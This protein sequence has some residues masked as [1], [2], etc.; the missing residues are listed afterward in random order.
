MNREQFRQWCQQSVMPT[1]KSI[2][3]LRKPLLMGVLNITPDS[4][5]D[6]GHF[7][8]LGQAVLRAQ[9][10]I[11][12]GADIIDIGGE[13]TKPGATVVSCAEELQRVIPVIEHI[14]DLS[15]ICISIDTS[16]AEVM[17]AAVTAGASMINDVR[18]LMAPGAMD[19]AVRSNVPV[20]LMHMQGLPGSMQEAPHYTTD[21]IDE[22]NSFF[23]QRIAACLQAGLSREQLILDPGFG[24]G[25]LVSHNLSI[26]K[27]LSEF[28]RHQLPLLLGVSRKSTIG[29]VLQRAVSARLS[30]SIA[31][32]VFA[33]LQG[34]SIIRTHDVDETNQAL[35]IVDAI[36]KNEATI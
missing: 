33:A 36:V 1:L 30:G 5:S 15:D 14:R 16:K 7:T 26:V 18:A 23:S 20:V 28:Q 10:L 34:A 27:N 8:E 29:E 13:S 24:F 21:V 2:S 31:T 6:G 3:Y 19:V 35:M 12:Q 32:T 9:E 11:A 25:K 22:I 17:E 4:F